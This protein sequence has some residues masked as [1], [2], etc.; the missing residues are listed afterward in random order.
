MLAL[1]LRHMRP[2]FPA[3]Y[4]YLREAVVLLISVKKSGRK[5]QEAILL[6]I[7]DLNE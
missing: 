2:E 4:N 3:F 5:T 7:Q 6:R 1:P